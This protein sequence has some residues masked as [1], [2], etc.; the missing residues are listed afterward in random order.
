MLGLS[1][2]RLVV[3]E[4]V[5]YLLFHI[6]YFFKEE[7]MPLTCILWDIFFLDLSAQN[8]SKIENMFAVHEI[9]YKYF[10]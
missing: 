1:K 8:K 10:P 4:T 9:V 7:K 6:W 2:I 3:T 5:M